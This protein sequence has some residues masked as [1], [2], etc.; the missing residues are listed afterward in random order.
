MRIK[1]IAI[2]SLVMAYVILI[3]TFSGYGFNSFDTS[4]ER[5]TYNICLK[6]HS[7]RQENPLKKEMLWGM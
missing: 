7:I 1:V 6:M 3:S 5:M 2:V 4:S